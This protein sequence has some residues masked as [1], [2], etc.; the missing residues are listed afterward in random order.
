M[1]NDE[2][3]TINSEGVEFSSAL[4]GS[5]HS[6][7]DTAREPL[8]KIRP[9]HASIISELTQ[10]F[11]QRELLYF[12]IWRDLKVRYKQTAL[13]VAW[14]ILQP[15]LMALIFAVF[16]GML[17]RVPSDGLPYAVF[18][19][20]GLL[21]WVFFSNSVSTASQSLIL[22]NHLLTKIYFP[23]VLLPLGVVAVRLVDFFIAFTVLIFLLL[24]YRLQVS[25]WG[26]LLFQ[27][28]IAEVALLSTGVGMWAATLNTRYRD[29]GQVLPVLLQLWMFLSPVMY[30][31]SLV[32]EGWRFLY[33][34][35]PMAGIIEGMRSSLF[36]LK[37]NWSGLFMSALL[38]LC[39][40]IYFI[41]YFCRQQD[42]LVDII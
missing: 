39:S 7:P 36:G 2:A 24:Y 6:S 11:S 13:G 37:M 15:L 22:N 18:A 10:A 14:V 32:P 29:V 12:F 31:S 17:A 20:T 4:R 41:Y 3:V 5:V 16:M 26:M 8:V 34:L 23:R 25:W 1:I 35:N 21:T 38:T 30:P 42:E 27:L 19:Y 9:G 28:L 40:F 33:Y